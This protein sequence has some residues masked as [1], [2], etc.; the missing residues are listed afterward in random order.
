VN[1]VRSP[2][3]WSRHGRIPVPIQTSDDVQFSVP[4]HLED[5]SSAHSWGIL[6]TPAVKTLAA[7]F[8]RSGLSFRNVRRDQPHRS[9]ERALPL[10]AQV[11]E[12]HLIK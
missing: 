12:G 9:C 10:D 3:P 11:A 4:I 8:V 2:R 5:R 7:A 1:S 6:E